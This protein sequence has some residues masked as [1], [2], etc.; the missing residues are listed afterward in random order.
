MSLVRYRHRCAWWVAQPCEGEPIDVPKAFEFGTSGDR[1][2]S[3]KRLV[4]YFIGTC[5]LDVVAPDAFP[6][7]L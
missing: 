7:G 2:V 6:D 5:S 4:F 1:R 3:G